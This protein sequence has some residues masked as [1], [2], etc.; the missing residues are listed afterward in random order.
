MSEIIGKS[1]FSDVCKKKILELL[2]DARLN[3]A[4]KI[5]KYWYL[6]ISIIVV[7]FLINYD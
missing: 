3:M 7:F 5:D 1:N 6:I 4:G 2:D